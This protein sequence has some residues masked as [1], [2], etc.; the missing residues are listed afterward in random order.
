[1]PGVH[2]EGWLAFI[3]YHL[4]Q[5]RVRIEH[6]ISILKGCFASLQEIQTQIRNAEEMKGAVKWIVTCIILH[7]LLADLKD[8]WNDLDEDEVPDNEENPLFQKFLASLQPKFKIFS[9]TTLQSDVMQLYKSMK[10]D[11][12][13]KISQFNRMALTTDLWTSSNQT[14]FMVVS[15]HYISADWTLRKRLI[16]FK[17]LP[18]P[19]TG[20][21]N[22]KPT[23]NHHW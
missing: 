17:E 5:S 2:K 16:G 23:H 6:A 9:Q 1:V 12:A 10:G 21:C 14:P 20:N 7:N 13:R 18:T 3:N 22:W 11:I 8:Q 15:A 4:A 19:H